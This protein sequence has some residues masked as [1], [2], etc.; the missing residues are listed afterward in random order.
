[1]LTFRKHL[2]MSLAS[3]NTH[4]DPIYLVSN[5]PMDKEAIYWYKKRFRIET[6]FSDRKGRGFNLNK[7]G[8]RDPERIDRL[9]IAIS[10]VDIGIVF[11]EEYLHC[12]RLSFF[13]SAFCGCN[14]K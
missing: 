7:S 14:K 11:L 6:L 3:R 1:M 12:N 5:F 13:S 8:L 9:L 10:L 4:D 2:S